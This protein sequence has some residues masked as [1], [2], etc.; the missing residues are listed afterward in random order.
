MNTALR[1]KLKTLPKEPG[2][3]FHKSR[4]GEI[5]YI[6]KAA[7]LR[8]RVRQYFQAT[9]DTR[10]QIQHLPGR[11]ADIEILQHAQGECFAL[12]ARKISCRKK[13]FQTITPVSTAS[14]NKAANPPSP[15][16]PGSDPGAARVRRP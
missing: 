11:V 12:P 7:S 13:S 16:M 9:P 10:T 5:I 3:Y 8:N 15:D 4:S 2:V 1:D 6:G 14:R